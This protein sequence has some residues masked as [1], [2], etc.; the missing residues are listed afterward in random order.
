[1]AFEAPHRLVKSLEDILNTLGDRRIT[2]G[3][4]LT[5]LYEEWFRGNVSEALEHFAQPRGEFTLV[6]EGAKERPPGDEGQALEMLREL[7][8]NG[9]RAQEAVAE[10]SVALK[11]PHRTVYRLWLSL[12]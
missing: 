12:C 10:V 2:I 1:V 8:A 4:E 11:L 9:S 6:I 7:R 3:R 5:K